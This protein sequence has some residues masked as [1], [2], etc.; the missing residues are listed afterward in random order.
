MRKLVLYALLVVGWL[1]VL[2]IL[3]VVVGDAN[4]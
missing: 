4:D 2:W 1:V 3:L